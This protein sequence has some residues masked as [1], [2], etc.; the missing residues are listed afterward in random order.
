MSSKQK[1]MLS[2]PPLLKKQLG[3]QALIK[4]IRMFLSGNAHFY[5]FLNAR[6]LFSFWFWRETGPSAKPKKRLLLLV[7]ST[8]AFSPMK[9]KTKKARNNHVRARARARIRGRSPRGKK[10]VGKTSAPSWQSLASVWMSNGMLKLGH[11]NEVCWLV[12]F[13]ALQKICCIWVS[14]TPNA[15][16]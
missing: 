8:L 10:F 15:F 3:K 11:A 6:R 14:N 13:W 12:I 9:K 16:L 5:F 7:P 1:K 4:Q 2:V